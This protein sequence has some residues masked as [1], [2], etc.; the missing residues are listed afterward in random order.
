MRNAELMQALV[1]ELRRYLS[2]YCFP[3]NTMIDTAPRVYWHSLPDYQDEEP[4]PF[5]VCRLFDSELEEFKAECKVTET[6]VLGLGVYSRSGTDEVGNILS[7]LY[8]AVL[9]WLH[10]TRLLANK[11][12]RVYPVKTQV[13]EPDRRWSDY[14]MVTIVT[15]WDYIV[16]VTPLYENGKT[17]MEEDYY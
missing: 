7:D 3:S 5:V 12:Q 10:A 11:F 1:R 13:A 9:T 17:F 6:I 16:P 14:H 4:Y 15:T 2:Q 8:D